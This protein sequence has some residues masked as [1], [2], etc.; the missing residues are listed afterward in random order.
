MLTG[1]QQA[2]SEFRIQNSEFRRQKAEGRRQK[3]QRGN[4]E[5]GTVKYR[6]VQ[7]RRR[8]GYDGHEFR[9]L[10]T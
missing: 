3:A 10:F 5:R 6:T 4:A 8:D 1:C 7:P 9:R 2:D